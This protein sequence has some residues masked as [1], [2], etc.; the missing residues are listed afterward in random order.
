MEGKIKKVFAHQIFDSRGVPTVEAF[1]YLD[2][3]I[4]ASASVPSGASKGEFEACELR[5]NVDE[6]RGKGVLYACKNVNT[7]LHKAL[8]GKGID[9]QELIDGIILNEDNTA[10]KSNLGA[11]ATLA[12]SLA[13]AKAASNCFRL[14]LYK[15]LGGS[16]ARLLPTPMMNIINGGA[17]AGNNLDIQ[18]FMIVPS[19]FQSFTEAMAAGTNIYATLKDILKERGLSNAVGDEGGFAPDLDSEERALEL[20]CEAI[21]RAGYTPGDNVFIA[22]DVASSEWA[23]SDNYVMPKKQ[24]NKNSQ[25]LALYYKELINKYPIVSIEDPFS[26]NDWSAFKDFTQNN[27]SLQ[28]VGDD[29]F[30]TNKERL[31]I[32]IS[33]GCA[34]AVLVKP[35]QIGT[36]SETLEVIRIAKMN[37]YKTIISHRSGETCDTS[38]ADI[39]VAVNA[40]QIK[41][42][43]P[44]RG[45]RIAKYNRLLRIERSLYGN[46]V[47]GKEL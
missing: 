44:A 9:D 6:Y 32:G 39:A 15:Y 14:P 8:K 30:V 20:I 7:T 42:G 43:A 35:N 25:E 24:L 27:P 17:H 18:E 37:S 2:N 23:E 29:L 11:N 22:L 28:I 12:V 34:N 47:F 3:G 41:A 21:E 36:L 46:G 1:V 13:C 19:G 40:G 10:D 16:N 33:E 4:L 31:R 45:E 38:I 5:D 26:E